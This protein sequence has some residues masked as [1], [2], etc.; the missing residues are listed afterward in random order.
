MLATRLHPASRGLTALCLGAVQVLAQAAPAASP[1]ATLD[2]GRRFVAQLR[3]DPQADALFFASVGPDRAAAM[4][5]AVLDQGQQPSASPT[6]WKN[7][8]RAADGL[9]ELCLYRG[10][11]YKASAYAL[12]QHNFYSNL[13]RDYSSALE[14]ARRSLD[15]QQR[16]GNSATLYLAHSAIGRDLAALGRNEEALPEYHAARQLDPDPGDPSAAQRWRD[17]I[18]AEIALGDTAGASREQDALDQASQSIGGIYRARAFLARADLD[19][20]ASRFHQAVDAVVGAQSYVPPEE[21]Q[22]F[23]IEAVYELGACILAIVDHA[24]YGDALALADHIQASVHGLPIGLAAFARQAVLARRRIAGDLDGAL[25]DDSVR[26]DQA[27]RDNNVPAQI[28]ALRSIAVTYQ[29]LHARFQR[30]SVLEQALAL[31]NTALPA[32]APDAY[33]AT[34]SLVTTLNSLGSAY[35][36]LGDPRAAREFRQSIALISSLPAADSQ[37]LESFASEARV[38]L[39]RAAEIDLD[40]DTAR[41]LLSA[42]SKRHP[43]SPTV[44]LAWARLERNLHE[45]ARRAA[46]LYQQAAS[47]FHAQNGLQPEL[48][49]RLELARFLSADAAAKIDGDDD[50]ARAQIDAVSAVAPFFD[51]ADIAWQLP[52]TQGLLAETEVH[53]DA[54]IAFYRDA[55]ARLESLRSG[56][57]DS[58]RRQA[59]ADSKLAQDLYSHLIALYAGK[60]L[61]SNAWDYL[62]REKARAFLEMLAGHRSAEPPASTPEWAEVRRIE[63]QVASLRADLS[64]P[65]E[66]ILRGSGRS[67]AAIRAQLKSLESAY[68]VARERA[69]VTSPIRP[70]EPEAPP[71]ALDRVRGRLPRSAALVEF[72]ILPGQLA[73]FVAT[74]DSVQLRSWPANPDVLK[75]QV[76]R[77]RRVLQS[78]DSGAELDQ[79]IVDLSQLILAP[80]AGDIPASIDRLIVVPA[81]PLY[82]IP[83][84]TLQ[85]SAGKCLLDRFTISYLPSAAALA[86]LDSQSKASGNLLL[87]AIGDQS[88]EGMPPLPGTLHETSAIAAIEPG[89]RIVSQAAF[90]HD[91]TLAAFGVFDRVHLATHGILDEDAPLFSALLT[92]PAPGQPARVSLYEIAAMPIHSRLV[93]LSACETGL[94]RLSG[95]D[96]MVGLTRTFLAAGAKVVVSSL[97]KVNDESTAALMQEFYRGLKS[98]KPPAA[99]MRA[100]ELHIRK[101]YPHPFYWAPFVVT[102]AI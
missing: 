37:H 49:V 87:G 82:Q 10:E 52:Y 8:H 36:D 43:D 61:A 60:N 65:S 102:G 48:T 2:E 46:D 1:P 88:I 19:L 22:T 11:T 44:A 40:P 5:Q 96:E 69:Q 66:A 33:P 24:S 90:T 29:A 45:Q 25:R 28:E 68:S 31:E 81:G 9:I 89:A 4:L 95:G 59:F 98:G 6:D 91:A 23:A 3:L 99:A 62:E 77:L 50:R 32:G 20:A 79:A 14:A 55:V 47:L 80:I 75:R 83:F 100:A 13:E 38:G 56:I 54:A 39:A 94:G 57:A 53:R 74:R 101:Q 78:P 15:L 63:S 21:E 76:L 35:L 30:V 64:G 84:E 27:R 70:L 73:A 58:S 92:S 7:L 41:D 12:L 18:Q 34:Y 71:V 42:E 97:W 26:L 86:A 51:D 67:P 85:L 16:S 17:L 93:V 72:A